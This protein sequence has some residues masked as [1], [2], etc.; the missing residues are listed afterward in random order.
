MNLSK[1]VFTGLSLALALGLT[2]LP[3]CF[4]LGAMEVRLAGTLHSGGKDPEHLT[5]DTAGR[6]RVDWQRVHLPRAVENVDYGVVVVDTT[7][8]PLGWRP[9]HAPDGGVMVSAVDV[10][11]PLAIA[12]LR[13]YDVIKRMNGSSIFSVLQVATRFEL[14]ERVIL[15]VVDREGQRKTLEAE[16][17]GGVHASSELHVSALFHYRTSRTGTSLIVGPSLFKVASSLRWSREESSYREYFGW[18][19]LLD[20][21]FYESETDSTTG[22]VRSRFGFLWFFTL[23]DLET[24]SD[25]GLW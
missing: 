21:F 20:F 9:K 11:A 25:W 10:A 15:E 4:S 18:S 23:G 22:E 16:A 19:A 5:F 13:P 3:G 2:A 24:E 14:K 6:P 12:G 8:L 17:A 7:P 1:K